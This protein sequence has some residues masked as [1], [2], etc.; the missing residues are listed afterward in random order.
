MERRSFLGLL[1]MPFGFGLLNKLGFRRHEHKPIWED[2]GIGLE[3]SEVW[4]CCK[5]D[6][7]S[8]SVHP[9][10]DKRRRRKC[11]RCSRRRWCYKVWHT[12]HVCRT[13]GNGDWC[14]RRIWD[15]GTI[16]GLWDT[17]YVRHD[18]VMTN[19]KDFVPPENL[20]MEC[21]SSW[22]VSGDLMLTLPET[23]HI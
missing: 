2:A 20:I 6:C 10:E 11:Y 3:R 23:D 18:V 21:G 1:T 9:L 22:T 4:V 5:P 7:Q 8:N 13:V 12:R 17:A 16:P 15:T 14:D 19:S